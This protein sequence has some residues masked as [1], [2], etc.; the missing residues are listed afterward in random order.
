MNKETAGDKLQT[1]LFKPAI[2]RAGAI[3]AHNRSNKGIR[4]PWNTRPRG[5]SGGPHFVHKSMCYNRSNSI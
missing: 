4:G 1:D 5:P 2:Y 3:I